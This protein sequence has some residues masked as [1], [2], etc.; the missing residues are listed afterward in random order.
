MTINSLITRWNPLI[1][2]IGIEPAF[3]EAAAVGR[4]DG[5]KM[6][7]ALPGQTTEDLAYQPKLTRNCNS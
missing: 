6:V 1:L 3:E 4:A 7:W 2:R 5:A